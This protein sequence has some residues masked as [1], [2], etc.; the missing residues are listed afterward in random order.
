[1]ILEMEIIKMNPFGDFINNLRK[2]NRFLKHLNGGFLIE[3][4]FGLQKGK[5]KERNCF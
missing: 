5:K 1:M 3:M 4:G 2:Y